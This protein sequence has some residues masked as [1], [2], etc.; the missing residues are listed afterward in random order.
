MDKERLKKMKIGV[1]LGG[2]SSE[3]EISLK[4]G[5]AVLASLKRSGYDAVAIDAQKGLV[6][7]LK[8][9]KIE[10]AF[11]ALHGKWG[12]DGTVQGLLEMMGIPYTGSGVLGSCNSHGQ[13]HDEAYLL[14]A[15]GFPPRHTWSPMTEKRSN[16]PALCGKTGK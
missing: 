15:R 14:N 2:K 12:E 16:S 6:E 3:R 7:N 11:I 1:L 8:K 13:G 10:V 9:E 5:S 4:S